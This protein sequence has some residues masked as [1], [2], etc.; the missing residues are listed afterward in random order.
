MSD[1]MVAVWVVDAG[2]SRAAR[3]RER[4]VRTPQSSV[5]DNVREGEFKLTLRKVPQRIYR[6]GPGERTAKAGSLE[7]DA[8][9]K[10]AQACGAQNVRASP[11]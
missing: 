1:R 9:A 10:Q 4:K 7:P 11:R 6:L 3:P 5:P 8:R 2:D